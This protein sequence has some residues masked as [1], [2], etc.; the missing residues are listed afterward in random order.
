MTKSIVRTDK[1]QLQPSSEVLN[2]FRATVAEYRAFCK[3][4]S[5]VVMGDWTELVEASSF[6][7]AVEKLIHKTARNPHPKYAYFSK[8]FYKFPSY[9]RRAAIEFVKGQVSSFLRRYRDW[10]AGIRNRREAKPPRFNPEAGCYPVLYRGQLIKYNEDLTV[11]EIKVWNGSDWLWVKVAIA[12][13]RQRHLTAKARSPSL[14]V[15][16][17]ACHLSVPFQVSPPKGNSSDVVCAV[18]V[19]INTLA[20]AAIVRSDGTVTARKFFHP[21]ADIDRRDKQARIIRQKARLTK[22]LH[23]GFCK[24]QYRRARQINADISQQVSRQI[25]NFALEN[26]ANVI[27]FE[28]LK[29]W[30]PKGGRKRSSLKQKF[31]GWLHRRLVLLSEEKFVEVGGKVAYVF[32]RGTSS[33]AFDGSGKVRRAS[34]QY[35][36]ATFA[37][38]KQYNADLSASYNIGGRYWAYQLKLTHRKDGRLSDGKSSSDKSRMPITLSVLW[39]REAPHGRSAS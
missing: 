38:G 5:Y 13:K 26:G 39:D 12:Q 14:I 27:V 16:D 18:D 32:A 3:A 4:L 21:A 23:R 36:L 29:G 37:S 35:E 22:T 34:Q 17:T 25:V 1:W 15:S 30:R 9:L 7:A 19:G 6:C 31:H 8:R 11:A 10:Q 33:W 2:Y 20:T 28:N 24:T